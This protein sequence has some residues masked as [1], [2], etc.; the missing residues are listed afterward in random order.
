[1][2]HSIMTNIVTIEN[3]IDPADS[4][5]LERITAGIFP[6]TECVTVNW[7]GGTGGA[8]LTGLVAHFLYDN[9]KDYSLSSEGNSHAVLDEKTF[10]WLETSHKGPG[11]PGG[12]DPDFIGHQH[13]VQPADPDR[14]LLIHSHHETDYDRF[15]KRWPK[16]RIIKITTR[17]CDMFET[18]LNFIRKVNFQNWDPVTSFEWWEDWKKV[19]PDLFSKY[20]SPLEVTVDDIRCHILN[21]VPGASV[22]EC[23]NKYHHE[24]RQTD[25]FEYGQIQA[26]PER[27]RPYVLDIPYY[28]FVRDPDWVL[29]TLSTFLKR[30]ITETG[31]QMYATYLEKQNAMI[32]EW[33]PW[34]R[35]PGPWNLPLDR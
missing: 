12:H 9:I 25:Y 16:G 22:E 17:F 13:Y 4:E 15:F 19:R 21:A 35:E 31:R 28:S 7:V 2:F 3:K 6:D 29:E 27:Y 33:G 11:F 34:L 10:N 26:I 30:P 24:C 5:F 18:K 14:P 32:A 23:R 20:S 1:M 8:A